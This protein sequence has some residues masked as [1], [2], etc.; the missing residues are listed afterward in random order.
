MK[1]CVFC[2]IARG[3]SPS[4]RIHEDEKVMAILDL[5]PINPG[6][7][8][9]MPKRHVETLAELEQEELFSLAALLQKLVKAV[10]KSLSPEGLNMMINQGEAAGQ[11]VPHFHWHIIPRNSG[12]RVRISA[13]RLEPSEK[14]FREILA[15]IKKTLES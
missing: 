2:K 9:V 7:V 15:K 13:R 6:H 14:E 3:E 12:D 11:V 10:E 5:Y 8:L 1:D 4:Y